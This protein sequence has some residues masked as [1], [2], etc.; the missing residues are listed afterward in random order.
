MSDARYFQ[1]GRKWGRG[2]LRW[3]KSKAVSA[4]ARLA[5]LKISEIWFVTR[6]GIGW[7]VPE[8]ETSLSWITYSPNIFHVVGTGGSG[9][10][11]VLYFR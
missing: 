8:G 2:L 1:L 7:R 11:N 6:G 3:T 5:L 9:G 10:G 4:R